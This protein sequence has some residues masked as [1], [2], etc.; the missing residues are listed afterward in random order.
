MKYLDFFF[1]YNTL[2]LSFE[3]SLA[4]WWVISLI[5]YCLLSFLFLQWWPKKIG[6]VNRSL[7][8]TISVLDSDQPI[9]T[10]IESNKFLNMRWKRYRH[11][12][13]SEGESAKTIVDATTFF[14]FDSVVS[15][16]LNLRY[17]RS[18]PAVL[19][20]MGILGT[21]VGLVVGINEF[22]TE[23]VE[24]IEN[25]IKTLLAGMQAAFLTSIWGMLLSIVFGVGEK[26]Q[27]NK[28]EKHLQTLTT[29]LNEKY[30]LSSVSDFCLLS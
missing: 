12:F 14:N 6:V 26:W 17:W 19:V 23:S 30:H 27:F 15:R 28:T 8:K 24:Q 7:R 4:I 9:N 1:P 25:S 2:F 13:L 3:E 29:R 10:T 22:Q 11:T 5:V 20:G 21:F 16:L 18:V